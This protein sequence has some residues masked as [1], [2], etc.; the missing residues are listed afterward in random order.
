V[1]ARRSPSTMMCLFLIG[2]PWF[3]SIMCEENGKKGRF[4]PYAETKAPVPTGESKKEPVRKSS[5]RLNECAS[6]SLDIHGLHPYTFEEKCKQRKIFIH[7]Q[8]PKSPVQ[9]VK[10][11]RS[12][13]SEHVIY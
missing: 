9:L 12:P 3:T 11:R 1:K 6:F 2:H 10:A 5:G 4:H 7:M 13:K 8:K